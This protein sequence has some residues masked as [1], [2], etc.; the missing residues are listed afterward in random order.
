MTKTLLSCNRKEILK[1]PGFEKLDVYLYSELKDFTRRQKDKYTDKKRGY[2]VS[3]YLRDYSIKPSR[4]IPD[5]DTKRKSRK[6]QESNKERQRFK[7]FLDKIR[8]Q[9]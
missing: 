9:K 3:E 4:V 7:K 1:L 2:K 6:A 5:Y 8:E